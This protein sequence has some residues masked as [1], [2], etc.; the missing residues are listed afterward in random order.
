MISDLK[1]FVF[2]GVKEDLDTF[3]NR[4]QEKGVIEFIPEDRASILYTPKYI[5]DI[6]NAI[7][8]IKH[9]PT[10]DRAFTEDSELQKIIDEI[11][12]L[13]KK[14]DTMQEERLHIQSEIE[15]MRPLGQFSLDDIHQIEKLSS[16]RVAFFSC[17]RGHRERD[18]FPDDL[19][20]VTSDHDLDY[21][22]YVGSEYPEYTHLNELT[23]TLSLNEWIEKNQHWERGIKE[24]YA[25]LKKLA[26]YIDYLKDNLAKQLNHSNLTKTKEST[27]D[28][29]DGSL[30]TINGWVP[31][32]K[33]HELI[34]LC[35]D[36]SVYFEEVAI[37]VGE[38]IPTFMENRHLNAV[39][40]DIV[41]IYD[42]PAPQDKDPSMWVLVAFALFFAMIVSD[43]GYGL[44]YLL[45]GIFL[46]FK[47]YK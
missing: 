27:S 38:K 39:G 36:L 4:A 25:R 29:L 32:K 31:K 41:N 43:A 12:L 17:K 22:I 23:F 11:L 20:Y 40:E 18:Q 10:E 28:Q 15:K 30:F 13:Q 24:A 44:I 6:V 9:F 26:I 7:K 42:V 3:F 16:K 1:K 35:H 46:R 47:V 45:L 21:F 2:I 19:I 5:E 34:D 14:I 37:E 33:M 8:I